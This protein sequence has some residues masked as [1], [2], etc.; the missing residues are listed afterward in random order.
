MALPVSA[1]A[2]VCVC[3]CVHTF[4]NR[5]Y[6]SEKQ[7]VYSFRHLPLKGVIAQIVLH[8]LDL[9]FDGKQIEALM[10]LKR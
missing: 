1:C 5:S 6:L 9:L 7:V 4:V 10:S 3:T 2:S 8:D